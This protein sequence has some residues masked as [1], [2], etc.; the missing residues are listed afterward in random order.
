MRVLHIIK[1]ATGAAWV[2]QQVRVL[3]SL[4]VEIVVALPPSDSSTLAE[5]K[6]IGATVVELDLNPPVAAP[7]RTPS[8]LAACRT[9]VAD[10]RPDLIHSHHVGT[11]LIVRRALGKA[12]RIPRIYQ[13][14]GPLHLEH[15]FFVNLDIK[16][17][18][19]QDHWIAICQ[20]IRRK[21]GELGVGAERIFLSY[22]G[23]DLRM[24]SQV[25]SGQLRR[26]LGIASGA[27][28]IGM[29]AYMYAPKWFLG[30]KR[31]LKGQEDFIT[32]YNILRK[33]NAGLRGVIIGG[34]WAGARWY[35]KQLHELARRLCGDSLSFIGTRADIPTLYPDL[36]LAVVPSHSEGVA[37]AAVE[38]LLSGV[39][40]V[41]TNVGG[42][43]DLVRDNE[44]GWLVPPR[45]P[46]ALAR[47][48]SDALRDKAE[49]G[50]RTLQGQRLAQALFD[51]E[52]TGREVAAIYEQILTRAGRE[53][54]V[55]V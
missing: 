4:G 52:R 14:A 39:P 29:V 31:G 7:W 40:V 19:P 17:A 18:G 45:N 41:A 32:A 44:T 50:R 30:Q 33:D 9:L 42:L 38:P 20:W 48:I 46:E 3:R 36:D 47:A 35:E 1:T 10:V 11:T 43:P 28:L 16:S 23:T 27:P 51:V 25:R 55:Y 34:P 15:G 49:A 24:F 26:E 8:V 5:Y 12:H 13:V 54:A 2:Y 21:Y 53:R 37:G 6:R 22:L